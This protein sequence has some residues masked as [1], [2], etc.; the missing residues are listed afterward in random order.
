MMH[1]YSKDWEVTYQYYYMMITCMTFSTRIQELTV[2][3]C[4]HGH[5]DLAT[6]TKVG[7]SDIPMTVQIV[8][9][10]ASRASAGLSRHRSVG[11]ASQA[12]W[13]AISL[14]A[15]PRSAPEID[16]GV[17]LLFERR[18]RDVAMAR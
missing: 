11:C 2:P 6:A 15:A 13:N 4:D 18:R 8:P 12:T 7:K 1:D 3:T 10:T 17:S 16:H 5:L 9:S 14:T